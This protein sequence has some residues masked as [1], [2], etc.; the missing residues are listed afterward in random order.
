MTEDWRERDFSCEMLPDTTCATP[1]ESYDDEILDDADHRTHSAQ[2][3]AA[4]LPQSH[5][6]GVSGR[7]QDTDLA[8]RVWAE[9]RGL[10]PPPARTKTDVLPLPAPG[11]GGS[12]ELGVFP[13]RDGHSSNQ[14]VCSQKRC[15]SW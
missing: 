5:P 15:R 1:E 7:L 12:V 13:R 9:Q 8:D 2:N 10:P 4:P 6:G 14:V 11:A 3:G